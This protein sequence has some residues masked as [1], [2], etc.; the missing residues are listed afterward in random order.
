MQMNQRSGFVATV[1]SVLTV[2]APQARAAVQANPPNW[3]LDRIDQAAGPLDSVYSYTTTGQGVHI[4]VVDSGI[5]AGH[6]DFVGRVVVDKDWVDPVW[7]WGGD[8]MKHGTAVASTA[9][10]AVY[11]VAKEATIHVHKVL[12]CT[13][14]PSAGPGS[15]DLLSQE[16]HRYA[17]ALNYIAWHHQ[18]PA[19]VNVSY[20]RLWPPGSTACQQLA[21]ATYPN[22]CE[23][24]R[25]AIVTLINV[26]VPVVVSSGNAA[27]SVGGVCF[28]QT[29]C[30][31]F[32]SSC[33]CNPVAQYNLPAQ[34][35][36]S[37]I[38]VGA[39]FYGS[40]PT[41]FLD[42]RLAGTKYGVDVYAPGQSLLVASTESATATQYFH[43]TSAAAAVVTGVVARYLQS[44]PTATPAQINTW[45]LSNGSYGTIDF[46]SVGDR[47]YIYMSPLE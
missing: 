47:N 35:H 15:A 33:T 43:N 44:H 18:S 28:P 32:W 2:L 1:V 6:T 30:D 9:A 5:N 45:I 34:A 21:P 14:A 11:G 31:P 24:V 23:E 8:C 4:Y 26:G 41:G 13:Y 46:T 29:G 12:G 27:G 42:H 10:G 22:A 16:L 17:Q 20:N 19:V 25:E 40:P 39:S 37:V 38:V 3:A 7:G 36:S